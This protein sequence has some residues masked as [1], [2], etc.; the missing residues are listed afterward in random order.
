MNAAVVFPAI[1]FAIVA[2]VVFSGFYVYDYPWGVIAFPFGAGVATCALCLLEVVRC[3]TGHAPFAA[4]APG[5]GTE[6]LSISGLAW[7]FSLALFLFGL[8]F[9]AGP[10]LYLLVCLRANGQSWGLSLGIAAASVAATWGLFIK[11][12]AVP[13]PLWPLWPLWS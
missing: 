10:A 12:L 8:G 5:V 1:I 11:V 3:V 4:Q 6:A 7:M 2:A 9:V 13:L